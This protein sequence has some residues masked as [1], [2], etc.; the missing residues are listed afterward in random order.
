MRREQCLGLYDI[1][2]SLYLFGY[3]LDVFGYKV[4][5]VK[6]SFLAIDYQSSLRNSLA[7]CY[8]AAFLRIVE[9]R[10]LHSFFVVEGPSSYD[11]IVELLFVVVHYPSVLVISIVELLVNVQLVT[12]PK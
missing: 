10:E 1:G 9:V 12:T 8:T 7:I 6:Y 11:L 4:G 5:L 2:R 3:F